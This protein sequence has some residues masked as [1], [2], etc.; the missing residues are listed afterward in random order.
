MEQPGVSISNVTLQYGRS[1]KAT[2]TL[3]NMHMNI[4]KGAMYVLI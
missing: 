2:P 4:P 3:H 1:K